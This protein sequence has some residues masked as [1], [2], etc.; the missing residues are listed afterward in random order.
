MISKGFLINTLFKIFS[1]HGQ[2]CNNRLI[3]IW[4]MFTDTE[5]L[6]LSVQMGF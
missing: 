1:Y 6:K 2:L 3:L 5:R 4:F